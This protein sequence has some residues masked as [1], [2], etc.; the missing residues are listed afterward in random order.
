MVR[1]KPMT[2]EELLRA[3]RNISERDSK[4]LLV[5]RQQIVKSSMPFNKLKAMGLISDGDILITE[6][7]KR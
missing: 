5:R 4:K 1:T 7:V 6:R 2:R 3:G